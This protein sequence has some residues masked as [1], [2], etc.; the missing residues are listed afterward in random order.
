[1]HIRYICRSILS[2][3]LTF[4]MPLTVL[5][6]EPTERIKRTTDK[7]VAIITDPELAAPEMAEK[8]NRML[9]ETVDD[10]FNWEA[11]SKRA[12][13]IH[14]KK[15]TR[16]EQK[17]FITL[18]GQLLERTY[19][20][21]TRHYSGE[22]LFFLNETIKGDYGVVKAKVVLKNGKEIKVDYRI[23]KEEGKWF[24]YD[25]YVEGVSL[26]NNYRVQFNNIIT[27]SSYEKLITR[28]KAKL[29]ER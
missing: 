11:F 7:L 25:V 1:M 16:E 14:W 12:L 10:V 28:L 8:R 22:K 17:E 18:F 4:I 21:K 6:G 15:R 5:A 3:L 27:R 19:M 24:I 13:A 20:D 29:E 2:V 9:R 23:K 26:V